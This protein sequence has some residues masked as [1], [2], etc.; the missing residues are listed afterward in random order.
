[1]GKLGEMEVMVEWWE[2]RCQGH[3]QAPVGQKRRQELTT[4]G[5]GQQRAQVGNG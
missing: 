5:A 1:M 4:N 2:L 3:H